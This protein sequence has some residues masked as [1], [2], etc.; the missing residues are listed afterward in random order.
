MESA[1]P[2]REAGTPPRSLVVLGAVALICG[3]GV[4]L[5]LLPGSSEPMVV[6]HQ[7]KAVHASATPTPSSPSA[8]T[9][10]ATAAGP[11]PGGLPLYRRIAADLS[12]RIQAGW[13]PPRG[14]LPAERQ[15]AR[16]YGCSRLTVRRA[17]AL[18]RAQGW[19]Y[20]V[21]YPASSG[22]RRR[23]TRVSPEHRWP[24]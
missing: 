18:L 16:E 19:V 9:P 3:T 10:P 21:S 1:R 2:A 7:V 8:S 15:L 13:W 22:E 5:W 20:L 24:V 23:L 6:S 4:A 14:A 11:S 12:E 17:I